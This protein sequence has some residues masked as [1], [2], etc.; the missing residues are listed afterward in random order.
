MK[1]YASIKPKDLPDKL[2]LTVFGVPIVLDYEKQVMLIS[3]SV[4]KSQQR[5]CGEYLKA[6]GFINLKEK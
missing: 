1:D 5:L 2:E 4:P 3:D 6:E